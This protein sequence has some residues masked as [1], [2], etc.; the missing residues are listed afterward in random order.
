MLSGMRAS[1]AKRVG[2]VLFLGLFLI[3]MSVASVDGPIV[4]DGMVMLQSA[5]GLYDKE[6]AR[7]LAGSGMDLERYGFGQILLDVP[8][9]PFLDTAV[10]GDPKEKA[11]A[12]LALTVLPAVTS[13]LSALVFY[14]LALSFGY[15]ASV[16]LLLAAASSLGTIAFVYAQ[17]HFSEP[18]V[19]LCWLA[20]LLAIRRHEETGRRRW[21]ALTGACLG[22]AFVTK[23]TA[24]LAIPVLGMLAFR[25]LRRFPAGRAKAFAALIGPAIAMFAVVLWYNHYRYG[26]ILAFGYAKGR[27]ADLAFGTPILTGLFGILLSPGK[28]LFFYSPV[29]VL[30]LIG[31]PAFLRRHRAEG[32]AIIILA[33]AW[34]LIHAKWWAWSG[35][36]GWGPRLM[37]PVIPLLLLFAAPVLTAIADKTREGARR[38]RP[39]PIGAVGLI[40]LSGLVQVPGLAISYHR[41]SELVLLYTPV[42]ETGFYNA[43]RWPIRDDLVHAHFIPEFSP[44]AGHVWMIR[45]A[46]DPRP[47]GVRAR[48]PW[49]S[50]HPWWVP[51]GP[52]IEE[53]FRFSP[54]WLRALAEKQ[55]GRATMALLAATLAFLGTGLLFV[56]ARRSRSI[57]S[58]PGVPQ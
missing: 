21:L 7:E 1:G 48:P 20:G 50:L 17:S 44:L 32:L 22:F 30:A 55:P 4:G 15:R 40:L 13:A 31:I 56:A 19:G 5:K 43:R 24:A 54:F 45:A 58:N 33:G 27:N 25:S 47:L 37:L 6:K 9:T 36:F 3:H 11:L 28:G 42:F 57:P 35:D 52:G 14:L 29:L 41:Y 18:T 49:I 39:G 53:R 46:A 16:S 34:L 26:D 23:T 38:L 10:Q 12:N 51:H 2:L 8:F